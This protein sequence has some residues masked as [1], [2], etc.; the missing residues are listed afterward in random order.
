MKKALLAV[1]C[2]SAALGAVALARPPEAVYLRDMTWPEVRAAIRAGKTA[3]IVPTAG[4][5]QNGPHMI[6]GKHGYVVRHAAGRIA[7]ALGDAVVAPV[8][9]YVPE[10]G[11]DPASGHMAFPGTISIP[12]RVFGD[13][14]EFAARS[15]RAHGFRIIYFLGDSAGNQAAQAR[16]AAKLDAAWRAGGVRVIHVGAYYAANGQTAWLKEQ[17][18]SDAQ[19]GSHAGIRDTSELMAVNLGGVRPAFLRPRSGLRSEPSG[20]DGD[21]A[22]ATAATGERMLSLKVEAAVRQ[23][24]RERTG[25]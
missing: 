8:V 15:F 20:V 19:I 18:F 4:I 16:V 7:R 9:D 12:D 25:R 13:I 23:I 2:A 24:R 10:G 21:P 22:L 17:G 1:L 6:L 14:L 3:V 5:E 11:I